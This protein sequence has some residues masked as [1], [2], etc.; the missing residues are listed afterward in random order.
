M[1]PHVSK[2]TKLHCSFYTDW[3]IVFFLTKWHFAL[4]K[5][6]LKRWFSFCIFVWFSSTNILKSRYIY[7]ILAFLFLYMRHIYL[8][9]YL[10]LL[11]ILKYL[12]K[13]IFVFINIFFLT[14]LADIMIFIYIYIYIYIYICLF[15]YISHI[16]LFTCLFTYFFYISTCLFMYFYL[17]IYVLDIILSVMY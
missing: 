13:I 7:F 10:Y 1:W 8:L 2:N 4:K 3:G 15:M 5:D 16:Y 6:F 11:K 14:Q 9:T 12:L 17:F